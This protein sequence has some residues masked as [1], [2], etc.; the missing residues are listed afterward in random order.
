LA[1]KEAE[2]LKRKQ[3]L[4]RLLPRYKGNIRFSKNHLS[5]I[6]MYVGLREIVRMRRVSKLWDD[7]FEM[8]FLRIY[9]FDSWRE[10]M[11]I[12]AIKKLHRESKVDPEWVVYFKEISAEFNTM[13]KL[14]DF[15]K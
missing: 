12:Q 1:A 15:M 5:N 11:C 8:M 14:K 4:A 10:K 9:A 2:E 3:M 7:T 6:L 13:M